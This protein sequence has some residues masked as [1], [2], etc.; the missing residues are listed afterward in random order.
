VS[1]ER[2]EEPEIVTYR[3]P[4]IEVYQV[5]DDELKRIEEGSS[6]TGQD[7]TF[8]IAS[9]SIAISFAIALFTGTFSHPVSLVLT[10]ALMFCGGFGL[11]TGFR[12][13]R[14]RARTPDAIAKIRSRKVEPDVPPRGN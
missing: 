5:T 14:A 1:G 9:F 3:I 7:L 13:R 12:W 11:Y 10:V 6:Q 2:R 8:A 4:R